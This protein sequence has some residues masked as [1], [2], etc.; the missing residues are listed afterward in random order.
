MLGKAEMTMGC[1]G[2]LASSNSG[3][4]KRQ[5]WGAFGTNLGNFQTAAEYL[6]SAL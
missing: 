1:I 5:L 2:D 4:R 6:H 3:L